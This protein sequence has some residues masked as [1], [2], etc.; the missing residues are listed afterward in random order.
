MAAGTYYAQFVET[1][2]SC[3]SQRTAVI[4][5]VNALPNVTASADVTICEGAPTTL[6]ANNAVTYSWAPS[7]TLSSA[8][9]TP[10]TA[11]PT[12]TQTYTVTGTDVNGCVNT[13]TITVT[14]TPTPTTSPIFHD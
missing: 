8:T 5:A 10:V 13:A 7:A 3:T 4:V 6:T 1:A 11:S 2:T 14:V 9:G 12:S